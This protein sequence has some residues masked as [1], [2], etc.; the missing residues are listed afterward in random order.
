VNRNPREPPHTVILYSV[1]HGGGGNAYGSCVS[2]AGWSGQGKRGRR[3]ISLLP[4]S[5]FSRM[6]QRRR[7]R[8]LARARARKRER[9][10]ERES[11]PVEALCGRI[12]GLAGIST[13]FESR[14]E[15]SDY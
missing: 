1:E 11:S 2:Y 6:F 4:R 5:K 12:V 13:A 15:S 7:E 9:E 10:R 14:R 3:Q 8:K